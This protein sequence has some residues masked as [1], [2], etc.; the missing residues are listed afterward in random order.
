MIVYYVIFTNYIVIPVTSKLDQFTITDK[1]KV[2]TLL[3][4]PNITS[5][6]VILGTEAL[7]IL[8]NRVSQINVQTRFMADNNTWPPEQPSSFTP[9]LLIHY[10]DHHAPEQ[11]TAMAK[12]MYT[13]DIG[14]VTSVTSDQSVV[15]HAKLD[16]HEKF[17]EI[18]APLEKVK[19]L[20]LF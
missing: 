13:G 4:A 11:V 12:L 10:Q 9:L 18:L 3:Y 2:Y 17:Q 19:N 14:K 20:V 15:K 6:L 1:G 16:S 7:A 5:Y 8:S